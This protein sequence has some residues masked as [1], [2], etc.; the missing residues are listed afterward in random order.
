LYGQWTVTEITKPSGRGQGEKL[1][2]DAVPE[3]QFTTKKEPMA[4]PNINGI[5]ANGEP[6]LHAT[7]S[8]AKVAFGGHPELGSKVLY[9]A[10]LTVAKYLGVPLERKPIKRARPS[11]R[12]NGIADPVSGRPERV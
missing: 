6:H 4:I 8:N 2:S 1:D 11:C 3:Q 10:E 7:L 12:K 9:H 5:I